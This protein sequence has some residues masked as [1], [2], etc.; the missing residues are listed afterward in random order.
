MNKIKIL[1]KD[2]QAQC[3]QY[4]N[5]L[6][7]QMPLYFFRSNTGSFNIASADGNNRFMKT[8][9][10]GCPD[11]ILLIDKK[12][13]GIEVKTKTGKQSE[14]QEQASLEIEKA[15]GYYVLVRS[16]QELIDDINTILAM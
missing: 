7:M 16:I 8:G 14:A 3:I 1:E 6:S 12:Y 10:K 11:I 5:T 15:G 4:L 13:I 9:K 2:I